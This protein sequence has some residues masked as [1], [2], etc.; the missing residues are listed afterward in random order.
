MHAFCNCRR[1]LLWAPLAQRVWKSALIETYV[2]GAENVIGKMLSCSVLL[3]L[4]KDYSEIIVI[5]SSSVSEACRKCFYS[6][7]H[8]PN[9]EHIPTQQLKQQIPWADTC[10]NIHECTYKHCQKRVYY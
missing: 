8:L 7:W 5:H 6:I 1:K 10:L 3:I 4:D 2:A 9:S